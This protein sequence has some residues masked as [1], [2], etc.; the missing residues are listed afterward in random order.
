MVNVCVKA[1]QHQTQELIGNCLLKLILDA[2]SQIHN[3]RRQGESIITNICTVICSRNKKVMTLRIPYSFAGQSV[4]GKNFSRLV[5]EIA[6]VAYIWLLF[7]V[8]IA[9]ILEKLSSFLCVD[10]EPM[11]IEAIS[12]QA[13]VAY[14]TG[15]N[16]LLGCKFVV[17][18]A[19]VSYHV[20]L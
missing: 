8:D 4:A 16:Q 20:G 6:A 3:W 5:G 18:S 10:T 12:R 14:V 15:N 17:D 11:D 19:V 9:L 2:N 7:G 13:F 1:G